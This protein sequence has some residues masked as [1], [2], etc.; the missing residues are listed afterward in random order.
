ML[1]THNNQIKQGHA[2]YQT[3]FTLN[4][5]NELICSR[6][7]VFIILECFSRYDE[8]CF[9]YTETL[10][11]PILKNPTQIPYKERI[12][13]YHD[14]GNST[15][16]RLFTEHDEAKEWINHLTN[17]TLT[18]EEEEI[19]NKLIWIYNLHREVSVVDEHEWDM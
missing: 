1:I 6:F 11:F 10:L 3:Q 7:A 12:G 16:D 9:K 2:Y 18:P 4:E 5:N 15:L 17:E 13:S 19:H 14:D 8:T